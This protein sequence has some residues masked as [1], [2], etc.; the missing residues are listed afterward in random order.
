ME[1]PPSALSCL[2]FLNRCGALC[3]CCEEV[4][5]TRLG[6]VYRQEL[7][8]LAFLRQEQEMEIQ[9]EAEKDRDLL[10]ILLDFFFY[11]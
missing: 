4:Q 11:N 1:K 3:L 6:P 10:P 2:F 9:A 5:Q 7:H 8:F